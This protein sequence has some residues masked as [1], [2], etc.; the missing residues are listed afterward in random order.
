MVSFKKHQNYAKL[1]CAEF[2]PR[3]LFTLV[4]GIS[5]GV[6]K[7]SFSR[8]NLQ[9]L[10]VSL[11]LADWSFLKDINDGESACDVFYTALNDIMV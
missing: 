7:F 1:R 10:Y 11:G 4:I 3:A 2:Y 5:V 6:P 8:A 9:G